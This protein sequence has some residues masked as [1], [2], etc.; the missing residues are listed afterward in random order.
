MR[1][2]LGKRRIGF[3][4]FLLAVFLCALSSASSGQQASDSVA[5]EYSH[6]Q[7]VRSEQTHNLFPAKEF[8][9]VAAHPL[10]S[11]AGY[12]I[13]QQG[14][15]A[16]DAMVTVQTVLG[17]VEPQSSGL[18]GG[19]F[20]LYYH[21]ASARLYSFDARETA[22]MKASTDLFL[23][24]DQSPLAFFD[25]VIGGLSVGTP[26]TPRLLSELHQRFG[27]QDWSTLLQ[28]AIQLAEQG[29]TVSPR[30]AYSI[31]RDAERLKSIPAA[32]AYFFPE[33]RALASGSLL[34]NPD[35]ADTLRLLAK[36]GGEYFYDSEISQAIVNAVQT[37][38]NKGFLSQADFDA[39]RIKERDNHCFDYLHYEVCTMGAPSSAG[40]AL[41]QILGISTFSGLN[42][43]KPD[44]PIAWQILAEA[45]RRAFADRARYVADPDFYTTPEALLSEAYLAS[46]SREIE[47]GTASLQVEAGKPRPEMEASPVSGRSPEQ[48]STS[49]FV[50]V[51]KD[52]N[53]LSMTSTI[54]NAFGSRLFVKG[55][56]LNNELTD[57]SFLPKDAGEWLVNRVEPGKRPRSS[58]SPSIVF[59][60]ATDSMPRQAYLALGSPGGSRIINFVS[61]SLISVLAWGDELQTAFDRPHILNR[62]GKMELESHTRAEDWAENFRKMGYQTTQQD[63][64]SGLHGVMFTPDGMI[65][66]ADKRREG[67]VLGK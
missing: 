24:E 67:L 13:L 54:E 27:K 6:R 16:I 28:P 50:I 15:S 38:A 62:F 1:L 42:T 64:N 40:M 17:L 52:G 4:D 5:P 7:T 44:D 57:F 29:F 34:K 63:I 18:G 23:N 58:M 65:G 11:K 60:K 56:F 35:Y 33:N 31:E 37:A 48:A 3:L 47:I 2:S 14:G 25:A 53:I 20:A 9:V 55:F 39:Y 30:L 49:H 51:D 12:D 41:Q 22:P 10:A 8:M 36:H 26:G 21:A 43:R 46:R 32:R 45:S 19:A 59:Q 66:A 61:Q